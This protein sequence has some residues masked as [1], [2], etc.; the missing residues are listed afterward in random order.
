MGLN[1]ALQIGRSGLLTSQHALQTTGN[2]LANVG[3]DGYHRQ[4][5]NLSPTRTHD[6][7]QG[8]RIGTGV[9]IDS[10]QREVDQAV[11]SRLR[12]AVGDENRS[13]TRQELLGQIESIENELSDAGLSDRMNQ[14]FNN[15]NE[16]ANQ[17]QDQSLRRVVVEEA[18]ALSDFVKDMRG[19][20]T[21]LRTQVSKNVQASTDRVNELLTRV[22]NL[23]E[24]IGTNEAAGSEA[25]ALRDER[26]RALKELSEY[27]DISTQEG[28]TGQTDVYV[29]SEPI[30]LNGDSRGVQLD[31]RK[32]NGETV[33]KLVTGDNKAELDLSSGKLAA[34]LRF[35]REDLAGAIDTVDTFAK[36]LIYQVNRKHTQGQGLELIDQV[37]SEHAVDDA[38]VGLNRTAAGLKHDVGH[39][40]FE[41]HVTQRST[42]QRQSHTIDIDL[43]GIGP[44][45]TL[46][47]VA[48]A[49]NSKANVSASVTGGGQLKISTGSNDFAVSFSDD[50]SGV[51]AALG[52]NGFFN[53]ADATDIAV[54]EAVRS[55]VN[56][57]AA[58]GDHRAGDNSTALAVA[59]LR[60]QA[61]APLN[62]QSLS[63][64]WRGHVERVGIELSEA[65]EQNQADQTVR[66][67]L[68][69]RQ[70]SIS[71][72]NVD[73]QTVNLMQHQRAF[74]ASA[75]FITT[76]DQ[77]M[78]TLL[79]S[80]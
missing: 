15:W 27:L 53:G 47:N 46:Q 36:Q 74:Q 12:A 28:K 5:V 54:D 72:V 16:L 50:T 35:E 57:L 11:E 37:T 58:S 3:T 49:I 68:H 40:S 13:Q 59:G 17:P 76:V 33:T 45:T 6:L 32:E 52:V 55:N 70:Q 8:V 71:G 41:L 30:V 9:G 75:R 69:E 7:Q 23:N 24:Q 66:E 4:S 51:L 21:K 29:G 77:L 42:G 65:K 25:M 39:G 38:T 60:D 67:N 48:N 20:L 19:E 14:F 63:E 61:V 26:D 31:E 22:E 43:D 56:R 78:Q 80:V 62:D 79:Q 10:I 44:D 34:Q 1:T 73:E 18:R 64:Y 2:N